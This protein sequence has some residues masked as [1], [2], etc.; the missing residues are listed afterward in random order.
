VWL[1][2]FYRFPA[3]GFAGFVG[4]YDMEYNTCWTLCFTLYCAGLVYRLSL[5]VVS[6]EGTGRRPQE[7]IMGSSPF[8]PEY[9]P[10]TGPLCPLD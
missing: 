8:S 2:S 6:F 3:S 7:Q 4:A 1:Y 9:R 5:Q 10:L